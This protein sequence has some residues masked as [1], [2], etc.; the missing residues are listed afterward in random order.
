[1]IYIGLPG[2][3]HALSSTQCMRYILCFQRHFCGQ[4]AV[5]LGHGRFRPVHHIAHQL[6]PIGHVRFGTINRKGEFR[7]L[8]SRIAQIRDAEGSVPERSAATEWRIPLLRC[9]CPGF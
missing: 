8:C 4:E 5:I 1:M 6:F 2:A 7:Q 3:K 9:D